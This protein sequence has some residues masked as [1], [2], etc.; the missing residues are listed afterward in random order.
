VLLGLLP[1]HRRGPLPHLTQ[2][3]Q[4]LRTPLLHLPPSPDP[5]VVGLGT[6]G[7]EPLPS[8]FLDLRTERVS[9]LPRSLEHT[10][11]ARLGLRDLLLRR[12]PRGLP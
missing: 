1:Q 8:P 7:K 5:D 4:R 11:G 2:R 10:R 3:G 12:P 9:A 6:G